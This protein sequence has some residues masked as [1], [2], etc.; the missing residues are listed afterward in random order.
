M[1]EEINNDVFSLFYLALLRKVLKENPEDSETVCLEIG[2]EIGQRIVED[3]CAKHSIHGPVKRE[4][5]ERHIR[6]FFR[7]Y[8]G[9]EIEIKGKTLRVKELFEEHAGLWLFSSMINE[10]FQ[11]LSQEVDFKAGNGGI[12]VSYR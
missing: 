8:L 2:K 12:I 7:T 1:A 4:S 3:F 6:S 5:I 10:V 11:C 9:K